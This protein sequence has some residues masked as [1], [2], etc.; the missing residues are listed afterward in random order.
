M[1]GGHVRGLF[2]AILLAALPV[3]HASAQQSG[4][5][6]KAPKVKPRHPVKVNSCAMYGP[7][8]VKIEGSNT[9]IKIGGSISVEGGVGTGR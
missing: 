2:L 9:C 4:Q 7:G 6:V 1:T 5:Q 3:C 8:F